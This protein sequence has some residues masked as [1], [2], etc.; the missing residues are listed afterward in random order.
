MLHLGVHGSYVVR[1]ADAGG[2]DAAATAARY[3]ITFQERPELRVDGARLISTGA[4]NA[5]HASTL[6]FEAAGEY[7][8]LFLQSEYERFRIERRDAPAGVT[9]PEFSGWYV[10]GSWSLTGE[11]RRY[12]TAT[13]AFDGPAVDHPFSLKDGTWGAW[14]LTGRYA[15]ID[16]NYHAGAAGTAPGADAVRGGDQRIITA[17]INWFPNSI[18]RFM[19]D[20]QDVQIR[21]L[22]P[23]AEMFQTP[24]GAE[25]GQRY[26][27]VMLRSQFAF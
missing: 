11:Q 27:A 15:D 18:V 20:Y 21:R 5:R 19:L 13:F 25:I 24:V 16:L 26:H 8:P 1:P 12:N 6:G 3:P 14:E 2:P 17:G 10:E 22:S 23:S 7:G 4:I 9:D